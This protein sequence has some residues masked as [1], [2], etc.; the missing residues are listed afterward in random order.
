[1]IRTIFLLH[2]TQTASSPLSSLSLL[3]SVLQLGVPH[4]YL[5]MSYQYKLQDEDQTKIKGSIKYVRL[6][7]D[8]IGI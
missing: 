3:P 4:T 2:C 7:K 1:M 6:L 8:W 5:M